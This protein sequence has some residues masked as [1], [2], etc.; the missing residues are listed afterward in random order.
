MGQRARFFVG[1]LLLC[2]I[3]I[4]TLYASTIYNRATATSNTE[5]ITNSVIV[6]FITEIDE[7]L[8]ELIDSNY[9]LW[10]DKVKEDSNQEIDIEYRDEEDREG[11]RGRRNKQRSMRRR[12]RRRYRATSLAT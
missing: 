12:R 4:Y 9:P 5:L 3:N 7:K 6:L 10:I 2:F 11:K 1:G 8:F